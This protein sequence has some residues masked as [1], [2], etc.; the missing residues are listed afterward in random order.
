MTYLDLIKQ[1]EARR[2]SDGAANGSA[3]VPSP[4][5]VARLG[6]EAAVEGTKPLSALPVMSLSLQEFSMG[7]N[8]LEVRVPWLPITLWMVPTERDAAALMRKGISRGRIWTAAE[9][10]YLMALDRRNTSTVYALA[11]AKLEMTGAIVATR[12]GER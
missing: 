11:H 8:Q 7:N 12:P 6:D 9:L 5:N 2:L 1:V 4:G 3:I 10:S